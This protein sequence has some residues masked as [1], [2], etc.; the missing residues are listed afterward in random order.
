M[1]RDPLPLEF[2]LAENSQLIPETGCRLWTGALDRD[3]YGVITLPQP[4]RAR[5][6]HRVAYEVFVGLIPAGAEIDHR[7]RMR[8]CIE[9]THI[10]PVTHRVNVLRSDHWAARQAAQTHCRRARH[11]LSGSNLY[12]PPSGGRACRAC[13][14]AAA[15][16]AYHARKVTNR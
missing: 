2:R 13:R 3:G 9:P 6:A 1:S 10:E 16:R 8:S 7:C 14:R 11:P 4:K 12:V 15:A 5:K